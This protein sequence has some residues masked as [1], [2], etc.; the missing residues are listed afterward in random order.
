[1]V[2]RTGV[3]AT[4]AAEALG[5][6][7]RRVYVIEGGMNAGRICFRRKPSVVQR[8]IAWAWTSPR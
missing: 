7:G 6:A 1:V 2:C 8:F 4:I 3:R 5:R